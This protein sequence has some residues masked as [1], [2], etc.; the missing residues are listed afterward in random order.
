MSELLPLQTMQQ[1][2][3]TYRA[4]MAAFERNIGHS[5][6]RW[7]ILLRLHEAGECSQKVLA[8]ELSMD[9]AALTR[10][11]KA[12]EQEG[13]IERHSDVRD[14][15]LTN[16]ALTEVGRK[17]VATALPK[18]TAFIQEAFGDLS[19]AQM[20]DLRALLQ[21]LEQGLQQEDADMVAA[22]G[23]NALSARD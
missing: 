9:P 2:G 19:R 8:R 11:I 6:P 10:Q 5:L 22:A 23:A 13:W 12:I 16:V 3:R 18:R 17:L 7:R 14:N 21:S 20:A 1:L 15:R 4:L